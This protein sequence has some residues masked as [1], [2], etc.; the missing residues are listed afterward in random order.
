M[1]ELGQKDDIKLKNPYE[2]KCYYPKY[3]VEYVQHSAFKVLFNHY[4]TLVLIV[5]NQICCDLAYTLK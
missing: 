5:S 3:F 2:L 1:F 4:C